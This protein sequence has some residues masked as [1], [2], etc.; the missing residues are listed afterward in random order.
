MRALI[1]LLKPHGH[2]KNRPHRHHRP[3]QGTQLIRLPVRRRGGQAK[4][5]QPTRRRKTARLP[6]KQGHFKE[7]SM[8]NIDFGGTIEEVITSEEFTLQRAREVLGKR[9]GGRARLRRAGGR[10]RH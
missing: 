4:S 3:V 9:N 2:Q 8:A 1:N 7:Y 10:A 6:A 5:E